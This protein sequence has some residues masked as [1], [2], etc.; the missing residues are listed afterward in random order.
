MIIPEDGKE[1]RDLMKLGWRAVPIQ[2][3]PP[4]YAM[5]SMEEMGWSKEKLE[6][7]KAEIKKRLK[8]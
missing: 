3:Y 4:I 8:E 6:Y 1:V 5:Y 2:S 7:E